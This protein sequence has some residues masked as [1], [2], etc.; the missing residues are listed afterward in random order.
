MQNPESQQTKEALLCS[1]VSVCSSSSTYNQQAYSDTR[2][3]LGSNQQTHSGGRQAT[4]SSQKAR[5]DDRHTTTPSYQSRVAAGLAASTSSQTNLHS[6]FA[7]SVQRKEAAGFQSTPSPG[8]IHPLEC[9]AEHLQYSIMTPGLFQIRS[10][11]AMVKEQFHWDIEHKALLNPADLGDVMKKMDQQE[12]QNRKYERRLEDAS[13]EFWKKNPVIAA[14]PSPSLCPLSQK[15]VNHLAKI[16]EEQRPACTVSCQTEIHFPASLDVQELLKDYVLSASQFE[17]V[18]KGELLSNSSLR[19]KLFG[20]DEDSLDSATSTPE[21]DHPALAADFLLSPALSASSPVFNK[22]DTTHTNPKRCS[23]TQGVDI[24]LS[25]DISPIASPSP[26]EVLHERKSSS[27]NF[28][29]HNIPTLNSPGHMCLPD[30]NVETKCKAESF[31]QNMSINQPS[32][33]TADDADM[34]TKSPP[35][36]DTTNL[37]PAID[38]FPAHLTTDMISH[39]LHMPSVCDTGYQSQSASRCYM[40]VSTIRETVKED[41]HGEGVDMERAS[42]SNKSTWTPPSSSTPTKAPQTTHLTYD[43]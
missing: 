21:K 35:L 38:N 26:C 42:K 10:S 6:P 30:D 31:L 20:N 29:I 40:D 37:R 11:P 2:Q 13:N 32:L 8:Y 22:A 12:K 16:D 36:V 41:L 15:R 17:E 25:P 27:S 14:S 4:P 7:T 5:T 34:L 28:D 33:M 18:N 43:L 3:T 1:P 24:D 39:S 19:R 23:L 9:P